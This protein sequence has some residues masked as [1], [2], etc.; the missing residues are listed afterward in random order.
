[1]SAAE[2]ALVE[3]GALW[4]DRMIPG[5][6]AL[7]ALRA[8]RLSKRGR[9]AILAIAAFF[10]AAA[11][12][13]LARDLIHTGDPIG[14]GSEELEVVLVPLREVPERIASG[15]ISHSLVVAAFYFFA[16]QYGFS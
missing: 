15:E 12:A 5:L 3:I 7:A 4:S 11:L 16:R 13:W 10:V 1:M 14:D 6:R 8:R 9:W 2:A